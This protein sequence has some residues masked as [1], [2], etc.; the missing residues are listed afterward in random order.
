MTTNSLVYSLLIHFKL[1]YTLIRLLA[2]E[3]VWSGSTLNVVC[4]PKL[5]IDVIIYMQQKTS[6][7]YIFRCIHFIVGEGLI[8]KVRPV[9]QYAITFRCIL[10]IAGD[11]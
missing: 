4:M 6:T 1:L 11:R 10:F 7:D 9:G 5:D 3:V 8:P 2:L